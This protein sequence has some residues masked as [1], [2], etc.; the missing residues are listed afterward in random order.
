MARNVL[1]VVAAALFCAATLSVPAVAGAKD[2]EAKDRQEA[3]SQAQKAA[4]IW[5]EIMGIPSD[6]KAIP[7]E[8]LKNA[9]TVAVF[10]DVKKVAFVFGGSGGKGLVSYRDPKTGKWGTPLFLKVGGASWGAQIGAE[11]ADLILVGLN[12]ESFKTFEK[13]EWTVGA[14]AG[15]VAGPVGRKAKAGTDWKLDAQF[16]SYSRSKGLYAGLALDGSKI[17]IDDD[18]NHAVYGAAATPSAILMGEARMDAS[19]SGISVYPS[20]LGKYSAR[21]A[22]KK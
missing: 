14:E 10:P 2:S 17:K 16:L 4:E 1:S 12:K 3:V 21:V 22:N 15:A 18:L 20:T 5:T 9:N 6:E 8:L 13:E 19:V 7:E 11:S